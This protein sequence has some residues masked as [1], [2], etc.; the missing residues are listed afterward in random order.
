M[1]VVS[2]M[3]M[4]PQIQ[5]MLSHTEWILL[6]DQKEGVDIKIKKKITNNY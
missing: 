5:P 2:Y 3:W 6:Y 1:N 4:L